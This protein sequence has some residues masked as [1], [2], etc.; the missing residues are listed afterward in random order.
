[1]TGHESYIDEALA[2][3]VRGR[4]WV[5]PNPMVGAVV[6]RNGKVIG[7]GW[8]KQFG[9]PH[10]EVFALEEAGSDAR[11]ATL[12]CTL[13]PCNHTGKTPPCVQ[14]V[15]KAGIAELVL[16]ARDP[17]PVAAGGVEA[18]RAA[19]VN[20]MLGVREKE[21]RALNAAFF[22]HAITGIPLVTLKWAMT[23]DGKIATASGDSKWITGEPAREFAH[24]L[25]GEHDAVMVGIGTLLADDSKLNCRCL[26]FGDGQPIRQPRRIIIDPSARVPATASL[27]SA[28]GGKVIVVCGKTASQDKVAALRTIGA[29]IIQLSMQEGKMP[30]NELL[31]ELGKQGIQSVLVEGG[32]RLLGSFVDARLGDRACV[33]IAPRIIGGQSSITAVGGHGAQMVSEGLEF[34]T[35]STEVIGSDVLISGGLSKWCE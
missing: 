8:H 30:L 26:Q 27:W 16:G 5:S 4:G 22:K 31:Q 28:N 14:T 11:G 2:L 21:C 20:V 9:G 35:P 17:N 33:F 3:A 23:A 34:K 24:R 7:R 32:S 25:R 19:G 12:F 6:V 1:M 18:L 10:A 15:I 13:E 29:E